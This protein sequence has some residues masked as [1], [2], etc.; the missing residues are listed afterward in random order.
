MTTSK[1]PH[2]SSRRIALG[3]AAIAMAG[4]GVAAPAAPAMAA[5]A[6]TISPTSP[7]GGSAFTATWAGVTDGE[8]YRTILTATNAVLD[9]TNV[10]EANDCAVG[11]KAIP[12]G[13]TC[14]LTENTG[15]TY[16]LKLLSGDTLLSQ[17]AVTIIAP[18]TIAP[19]A[20]P[21][22]TDIPA[23]ANDVITI[24]K[25]DNIDWSY[26]TGAGAATPVTFAANETS[27]DVAIVG[28]SDTVVTATP[29]AGFV[30]ADGAQSVW[31]FRLGGTTNVVW[32]TPAAPTASDQHGTSSDAV[33]VTKTA[34]VDWQVNGGPVV[35]F[36]ANATTASV[37][38][39]G[40]TAKVIATALAGYAFDGSVITKN[41]TVTF[42]G[43]PGK[44]RAAGA[45]RM[46]TAVAVSQKFFPNRTE[47]VYIAN[48]LRFPDA[49]AAGPAAAEASSPLLLTAG[50]AVPEF[51]LTEVRRL[52]PKAIYIVGGSDVVSA[53][54]ASQLGAIASVTR[55][56]GNDRHATAAEVS[57]R[58]T[59]AATVYLATGRDF[60]DALSGGSGAA[61]ERM[62]LL[63][64]DLDTVPDV[65]V[66]A[67][68]RL[69]PSKIV[70][71]GGTGVLSDAVERQAKGLAAS[72]VRYSGADRYATSADVVAKVTS[73]MVPKPTT[74][75]LATGRNYPDALAGVP[76]AA[77]AKAPLLLTQPNCLPAVMKTVVDGKLALDRVVRLGSAEIVGDFDLSVVCQ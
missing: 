66:T 16:D 1:T 21:V 20:A 43:E 8:T 32:V 69:A 6:V 14:S 53:N 63:L 67:I 77:V 49:L 54:V 50:D 64:A 76:A 30:I 39:T 37:P 2:R 35:T 70:L 74:A 55:L 46:A 19:S 72:V 12:T 9:R 75:L 71:V 28:G 56:A 13:L 24:R 60:P 52:A 27:K 5:P 17:A 65:T 4:L 59:S 23:S 51:V 48:G 58:W 47:A 61:K 36:A 42:S 33:V 68:R 57:K 3:A 38:V 25:V 7:V 62:P 73:V 10:A 45:D 34:G 44:E 41:Y 40:A 26:K 31:T 29:K 18:I 22:A 15:G 11:K